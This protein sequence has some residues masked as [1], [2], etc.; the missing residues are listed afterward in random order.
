MVWSAADL[1]IALVDD[2]SGGPVATIAIGTPVGTLFVM[3]EPRIEGRTLH[4]GAIHVYGTGLEPNE[5]GPAALRC[6]I[7]AVLAELDCDGL[8]IEGAVRTTGA[9]PG[10]RTRSIRFARRARPETG[11][12]RD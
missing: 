5:I 3:G 4:T 7:D 1:S 6:L 10:P 2:L 9:N 12:R 11:S 8:V